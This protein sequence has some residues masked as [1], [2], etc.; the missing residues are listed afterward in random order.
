V[1]RIASFLIL[2]ALGTAHAQVLNVRGLEMRPVEPDV[3]DVD[4]LAQSLRLQR[5]DLRLST[6]FERVYE[7]TIPRSPGQ[8]LA[9]AH[10][11]KYYVRFAG[12]VA[13]VFP[14]S[15]YVPTRRGRVAAI[16]AGTVFSIGGPI[17]RLIGGGG[18]EASVRVN[19]NF[20]NLSARVAAP[21]SRPTEP[22]RQ[23][24]RPRNRR[25]NR[26]VTLPE[27]IETRTLW[28]DEAY[29]QK[30]IEVLVEQALKSASAS[31]AP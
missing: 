30:R 20:V 13:A 1:K 7:V 25:V 12:G 3:A 2:V 23:L 5:N 31:R 8:N 10:D 11:P 16:P 6:N 27:A 29:R 15:E 21:S 17:E 14:R 28:T 22:E 19:P 24:E 9:G 4:P 26:D 18:A